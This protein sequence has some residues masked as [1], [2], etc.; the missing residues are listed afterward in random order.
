MFIGWMDGWGGEVIFV[1]KGTKGNV[2]VNSGINRA[3]DIHLEIRP[4]A[5]PVTRQRIN[6]D[7]RHSHA[8][9][10]VKEPIKIK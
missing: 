1:G 9:G 10:K 6:L 8:L 7:F 4:Q 5:S 2:L 3:A